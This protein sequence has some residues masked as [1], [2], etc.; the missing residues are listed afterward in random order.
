MISRTR[1]GGF[2]LIEVLVALGIVAIALAAGTRATLALTDNAQRQ[3]DIV[4]AQLC[5]ENELAR[6][7][8]SRQMPGVG[9]SD[10]PCTQGGRDFTV[11]LSVRPTPNPSFR[12]VDAQVRDGE[13]PVL[14]LS[15]VVG[16][17]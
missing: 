11:H 16:R 1:Q 6:N 5:A 7:R 10:W 3:S 13:T 2:T 14:S 4:L 9:D 17:Y 8:L 12:R 15:T